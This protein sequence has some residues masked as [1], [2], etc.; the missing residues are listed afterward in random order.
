MGEFSPASWFLPRSFLAT[1][2]L[3][4]GSGQPGIP[5][6][7]SRVDRI[8]RVTQPMSQNRWNDKRRQRVNQR[9]VPA[10]ITWTPI[11]DKLQRIYDERMDRRVLNKLWRIAVAVREQRKHDG[12]D[13]SP[14]DR[15]KAR[16]KNVV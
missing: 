6:S 13:Q 7:H 5:R 4:G 1:T 3:L 10:S 2:E 11:I 14:L 8:Q 16:Y 12:H 9:S 15:G